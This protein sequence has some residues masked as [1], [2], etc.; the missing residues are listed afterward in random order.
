MTFIGFRPY[1]EIIVVRYVRKN[2]LSRTRKLMQSDAT[3]SGAAC[4]ERFPPNLAH[5]SGQAIDRRVLAVHF[6]WRCIPQ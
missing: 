4:S 5:R 1:H 3:S 6:G 2:K